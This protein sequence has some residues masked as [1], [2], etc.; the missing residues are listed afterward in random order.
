MKEIYKKVFVLNVLLHFYDIQ[1]NAHQ[2]YSEQKNTTVLSS[3]GEGIVRSQ[4]QKSKIWG[5]LVMLY[6]LTNT[7]YTQLYAFANTYNRMV[8]FTL[9]RKN[10]R[11]NKTFKS[12]YM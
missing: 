2:I 11:K 3:A 4:R 6:I 12:N 8:H 10:K 1:V 7:W 5:I 9:K